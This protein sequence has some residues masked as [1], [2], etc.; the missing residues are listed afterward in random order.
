MCALCMCDGAR[1][2]SY[3]AVAHRI[4]YTLY[5]YSVLAR[6]VSVS[7]VN[8]RAMEAGTSACHGTHTHINQQRVRSAS[9]DVRCACAAAAALRPHGGNLRRRNDDG[10]MFL[11]A[12]TTIVD[13]RCA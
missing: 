6:G 2:H 13:V 12:T 9:K 4:E 11:P 1:Y 10:D 5:V 8:T 7:C 3:Y